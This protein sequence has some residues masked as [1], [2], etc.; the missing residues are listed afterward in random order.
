[1]SACDGYTDL[2]PAMKRANQLCL[3]TSCLAT[4]YTFSEIQTLSKLWAPSGPKPL[5]QERFY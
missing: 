1:M 2:D 4:N 3:K 5:G